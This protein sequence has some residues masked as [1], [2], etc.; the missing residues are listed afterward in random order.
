MTASHPIAP[1]PAKT[2]GKIEKLADYPIV[3][4]VRTNAI[5]GE[6][7]RVVVQTCRV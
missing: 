7:Q 5:H 1:Q 6:S 3:D 4:G 2:K